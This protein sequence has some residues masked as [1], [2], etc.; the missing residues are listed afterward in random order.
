MPE[1]LES[2]D[3]P[4]A[5]QQSECKSEQ[6]IATM[7]EQKNFASTPMPKF[8]HV[9]EASKKFSEAAK[10]L[11]SHS[12]VASA[13]SLKAL[14]DG[15]IRIWDFLWRLKLLKLTDAAARTL[16]ED[17]LAICLVR[18]VLNFPWPMGLGESPDDK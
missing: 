18:E 8:M 5:Q 17:H 4:L 14:L 15:E 3:S 1:W 2:P 11:K 13:G 6:G 7:I 16:G 10:L 9:D 12:D